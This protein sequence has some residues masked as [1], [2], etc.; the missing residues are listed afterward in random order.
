MKTCHWCG[1]PLKFKYGWVHESDGKFL[2]TKKVIDPRTG[3]EIEVDDHTALAVDET[4]R[5]NNDI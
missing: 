3:N 5:G 1:E 2:R 4:E